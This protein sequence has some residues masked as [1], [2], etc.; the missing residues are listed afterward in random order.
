ML[1]AF[2]GLGSLGALAALPTLRMCSAALSR[3]GAAAALSQAG[4]VAGG[5]S[6]LW[7][8]G[9]SPSSPAI[10]L[11]SRSRPLACLFARAA[12]SSCSLRLVLCRK[13]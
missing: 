13:P 12:L 9:G 1:A 11:D 5:S 4:Q 2:W 10:L 3:G 8:S 7:V 6:A